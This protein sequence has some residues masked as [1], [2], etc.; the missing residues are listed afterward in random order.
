MSDTSTS[1]APASAVAYLVVLEEERSWRYALPDDGEIVIGRDE[2]CDVR[3][4]DLATSRRHAVVRLR[5]GKATLADLGSH[6]GTSVDGERVRGAR[7]LAPGDVITICATTIAYHAPM[8]RAR[9]ARVVAAEAFHAHV[10][11]ELDRA[12]AAGRRLGVLVVKLGPSGAAADAAIRALAPVFRAHDVIAA[13]GAARVIVALPE[14]DEEELAMRATAVHE[15]LAGVST[16]GAVAPDD[17]ADPGVLLAAARDA[18]AAALEGRHA[19]A[20]RTVRELRLGE[21]RILL[22]EPSMFR[23]YALLERIAPSELPVLVLGET[24]VGKESVAKAVHHLSPRRDRPL[25][26]VNCAALPETLAESTL[27]GH[28][29][30]AFSGAVT[31]QVG[32]FEA[33]HGGTLFLDE[34]GELPLP[35]QAKLLRALDGKR[36]QRLGA[37]QDRPA[38]VRIVAATNRDLRAE[39]AAGRFREDLYFRL[40]GALVRVPPLRE[41]PRELP[42]LAR[43]LLA[44]AC[45]RLARAVPAISVAAM[46]ALGR[47]PWPGNVRELRHAMEFVAAALEGDEVETWHLPQAIADVPE[48]PEQP[49]AP[50]PP[51]AAPPAPHDREPAASASA[52]SSPSV[53]TRFRPIAEELRELER[54]R[55]IQALTAAG[56]VQTRAAELLRMPRRT[57]VAKMREH[58]LHALFPRVP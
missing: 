2:T 27:F 55:M 44:Q 25:I 32:T 49:A 56:G 16:G 50:A 26:S 53:P 36:V 40:S 30:G 10:A 20:A 28:E 22:A 35:I 3:L 46:D 8:R 23:M 45:V 39:V 34:V 24:G 51:A 9:G 43:E 37:L 57:F 15:L 48:D 31:A 54:R 12:L 17:A 4:D 52:A 41:R 14:L 19:T 47:Y 5:G 33:A 6:N 1:F 11:G 13:D 21:H 58:D 42:V 18:A 38:D 29:R 7:P